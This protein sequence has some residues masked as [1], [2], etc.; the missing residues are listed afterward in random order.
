MGVERDAVGAVYGNVVRDSLIQLRV[1]WDWFSRYFGGEFRKSHFS[2]YPL[3][4]Q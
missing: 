2:N 4:N 3:Y 1:D